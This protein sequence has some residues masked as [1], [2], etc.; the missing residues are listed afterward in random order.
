[1]T[2]T[3]APA[4]PPGSL[5]R[6]YEGTARTSHWMT[7]S[8]DASHLLFVPTARAT[9][10]VVR[11]LVTGAQ[12][13]VP[14]PSPDASIPE[15]CG[16]ST[17]RVSAWLAEAML[18]P[19]HRQIVYSVRLSDG[20]LTPLSVTSTGT[21]DDADRYSSPDGRFVAIRELTRAGFAISIVNARTGKRD[22]IAEPERTSRLS[23]VGWA[24]DGSGL[25]PVRNDA[26]VP[27]VWLQPL[28]EGVS[29][30]PPHLLRAVDANDTF[31]GMGPD[32]SY[33]F[34]KNT[35]VSKRYVVALD[36]AT[37]AAVGTPTLRP[38]LQIACGFDWSPDGASI[39][40]GARLNQSGAG[41][42]GPPCTLIAIRS[43]ADGSERVLSPG[44]AEVRRPHWSRDGKS[45][46]VFGK[47]D[48]TFGVFAV[49][50]NANSAELLVEASKPE[51]A[52]DFILIGDWTPDGKGV[53]LGRRDSSTG[54]GGSRVTFGQHAAGYASV[55][56][57]R[58]RLSRTAT[59]WAHLKE[60]EAQSRHRASLAGCGISRNRSRARANWP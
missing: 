47:K 60:Q 32:G 28:L 14:V 37:G 26:D 23:V 17:G 45:L 53:Y 41:G 49:N 50:V 35:P 58:I 11:D 9:E 20:A 30:G 5:R 43:L 22:R 40:T 34:E 13:R 54:G 33:Y 19:D 2:P 38:D 3:F 1:M 15:W 51:S 55:S 18:S 59:P 29:Q 57:A 31:L 44:L 42:S 16:E 27:G 39:A 6:V 4:S 52:G 25:V 12:T 46:L 21:D 8:A 7:L 56:C 24:P 36:P 10:F 48:A